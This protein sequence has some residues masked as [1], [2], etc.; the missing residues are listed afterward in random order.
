MAAK[1]TEGN[2]FPHLPSDNDPSSLL[3]FTSSIVFSAL[4][5]PTPPLLLLLVSSRP[6]PTPPF[7]HGRWP[8]PSA[9]PTAT[10][11]PSFRTPSS[12]APHGSVVDGLGAAVLAAELGD[13]LSKAA[14][15]ADAASSAQAL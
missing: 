14:D 6:A 9:F 8:P 5:P 7:L 1:G 2:Q 4:L 15:L 12:L 10:A 13:D 11:A 3:A